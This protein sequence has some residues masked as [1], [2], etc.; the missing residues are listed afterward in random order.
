M[1]GFNMTLTKIFHTA[2]MVVMMLFTLAHGVV[3]LA[4]NTNVIDKS[5]AAEIAQQK[6]GGELFG[7][8]KKIDMPDGSILYEVRL[9]A[10]GRMTI[11]YVDG[12]GNIQQKR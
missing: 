3:A 5:R 10:G 12:Q 8:I 9:D 7:K 2:I 11:V 1:N 6:F 4:Q